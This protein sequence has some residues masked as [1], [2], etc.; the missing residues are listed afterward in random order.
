MTYGIW[1][2]CYGSLGY[3]GIFPVDASGHLRQYAGLAKNTREKNF[4]KVIWLSIVWLIWKFRNKRIF[5][6]TEVNIERIKDSII[7]TS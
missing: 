1:S 2:L 7:F 3:E 5:E 4:W 6:R